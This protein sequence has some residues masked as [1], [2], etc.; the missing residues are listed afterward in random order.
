[1]LGSPFNPNG[2]Q[3][4][5]FPRDGGGQ[6][7][8]PRTPFTNTTSSWDSTPPI[9]HPDG[10]LPAY[11][12]EDY[13]AGDL[14]VDEEKGTVKAGTLEALVVRLTRHGIAGE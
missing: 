8:S 13:D 11:L 6:S 9:I 2:V 12:S 5:A 4:Q 1:M 3:A 14:V 7:I 10:R